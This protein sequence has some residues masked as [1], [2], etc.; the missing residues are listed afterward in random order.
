MMTVVA[1]VIQLDSRI[2]ICQRRRD[3]QFPLKWEFPGGKVEPGESLQ[4]ALVRELRE[5]L[6]VDATVGREIYRTKYQYPGRPEPI[7]VIF[8]SATIEK[9][10][11]GKQSEGAR[12]RNFPSASVDPEAFEQVKWVFPAELTKYDFLEANSTLI[13]GLAKMAGLANGSLKIG[14]SE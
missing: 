10:L 13:A 5:E 1:A 9:D 12:P 2:L 14:D 11:V 7:E 8:F 6:G 3:M 4:A